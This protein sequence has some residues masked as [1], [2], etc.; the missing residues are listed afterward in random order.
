M[1]DRDQ[2]RYCP[3][4]NVVTM[5]I[6][7]GSGRKQTCKDCADWKAIDGTMLELKAKHNK[8]QQEENK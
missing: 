3:A 1:S 4:C 6:V 2:W 5:H 8:L 7:S